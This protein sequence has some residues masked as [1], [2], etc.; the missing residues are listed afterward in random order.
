[1]YWP[2]VI[3]TQS[4]S[5]PYYIIEDRR[6]TIASEDDLSGDSIFDRK[7]QQ[8]DSEVQLAEFQGENMP[9]VTAII[10]NDNDRYLGLVTA[11]NAKAQEV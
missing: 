4:S 3:V 7:Y 6:K 1:M 5:A 10:E 2:V 9:A 11:H 8:I